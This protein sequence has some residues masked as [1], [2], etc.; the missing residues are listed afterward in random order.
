M[1]DASMKWF[2]KYNLWTPGDSG[3]F[4]EDLR[5]QNYFYINTK[6]SFAFLIV[7]TFAL[8]E[9]KQS[10]VK[11]LGSEYKSSQRQQTLF[12]VITFFTATHLQEM[13]CQFH[14]GM[15]LKKQ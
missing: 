1:F 14:L 15:S 8:R 11:W 6:D 10:Q 9:W 5:G 3:D 7:L 2:S 13:P 12:I 4:K